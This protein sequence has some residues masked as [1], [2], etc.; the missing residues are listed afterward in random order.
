MSEERFCFHADWYDPQ[1]AFNRRYQLLYYPS[2][3]SVELFEIKTKR[4][5]LKRSRIETINPSDLYIGSTV[6]ILSRTMKIVEYGDVYTSRSLSSNQQRTTAVLVK[7]HLSKL[8]QI[9]DSV[10][11]SGIKISKMRQVQ[12]NTQDAYHLISTQ[13]DKSNFNVCTNALTE[14]P[15]V[16]MELL[17]ADALNKWK[18]VIG[19]S[20]ITSELDFETMNKIN[21]NLLQNRKLGK[22]TAVYNDTTCCIIKPHLVASGMAGAAIYEIQRA[23]YDISAI[24]ALNFSKPNAEEFLEVYKGVLQ[25]YPEMVE[26]LVNGTC[27]ALEVKSQGSQG[28]FRDFCGPHDPEIARTLR[29]GTL[30]ALFGTDKIKNAVHCTDLQEDSILEVEYF[31]RILDQI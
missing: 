26:E 1:A 8:G 27:F 5:F 21:E 19:V 10:Y 9:I 30:R 2:D 14:G 13:R 18:S 23:G 12:L 28:T 15:I 4:H 7:G 25:E 29:P 22:N 11:K 16:V 20:D 24:M 6:T 3:G 31:F 17:G